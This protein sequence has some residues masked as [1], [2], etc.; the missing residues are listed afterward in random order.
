MFR[1][2]NIILDRAKSVLGSAKIYFIPAI[3]FRKNKRSPS[4]VQKNSDCRRCYCF[5]KCQKRS[6]LTFRIVYNSKQL[7]DEV[8]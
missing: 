8:N 3:L 7:Y 4:L 1:I 5:M 2:I 6:N